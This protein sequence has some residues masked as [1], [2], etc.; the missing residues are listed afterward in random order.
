MI[1]SNV[2]LSASM[3]DDQGVKFGRARLMLPQ[4]SPP[5]QEVIAVIHPEVRGADRSDCASASPLMI[6]QEGR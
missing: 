2:Y 5:N 6:L 3:A 4:R 1:I